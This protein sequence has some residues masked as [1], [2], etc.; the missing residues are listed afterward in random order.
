MGAVSCVGRFAAKMSYFTIIDW[1]DN[2]FVI[3]F[4]PSHYLKLSQVD[5]C[6]KFR[7]LDSCIF[8]NCDFKILFF[9]VNGLFHQEHS[10]VMTQ[11]TKMHNIARTIRKIIIWSDKK[12]KF[13]SEVPRLAGRGLQFSFCIVNFVDYEPALSRP[14]KTPPW[15]LGGMA[16]S[17]CPNGL[18]A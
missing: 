5:K 12:S 18:Q 8:Q 3:S 2:S 17:T 1:F 13:F 4:Y 9:L 7:I 14:S 10:N 6:L 11:F 16:G 15:P